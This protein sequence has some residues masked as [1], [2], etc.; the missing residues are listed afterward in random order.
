MKTKTNNT[1]V[2]NTNI[3]LDTPIQRGEQTITSISLR[4]PAA[5]EL[6]GVNLMDVAHMDVTAL[7]KVIPRIS[8]PSLT[9][10]EVAGLNTSDLMQMGVAVASFLLPTAMKRE[11]YQAQ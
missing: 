3:E 4:K 1:P 9:E 6:R 11:L 7:H 5:G 2:L 8:E 10:H